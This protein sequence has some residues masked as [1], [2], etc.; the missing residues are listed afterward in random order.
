MLRGLRDSMAPE[1]LPQNRKLLQF[2]IHGNPDTT[3]E[4]NRKIFQLIHQY[5]SNTKRFTD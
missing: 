3:I 2:I 5:L 1:Q 4:M